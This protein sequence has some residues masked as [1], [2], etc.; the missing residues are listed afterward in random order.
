MLRHLGFEDS[1]ARQMSV[2]V[3]PNGFEW[4]NFSAE[5]QDQEILKA[6]PHAIF[7]NP[8]TNRE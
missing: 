1:S 3:D 2:D 5:Q 6:W 7:T 8:P 4:E